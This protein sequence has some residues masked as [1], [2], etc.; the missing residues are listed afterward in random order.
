MLNVEEFVRDN[1]FGNGLGLCAVREP[2]HGRPALSEGLTIV[3][4]DSHLPLAEDIWFD[5][6]PEHLKDKAPRIWYDEKEKV[7]QIGFNGETLYPESAYPLIRS[8]EDRAGTFDLDARMADLDAEDVAKEIVF[9]QTLPMFF[10]HKDYEVRE[11]IFRGYNQYLAQLQARYPTRFFPVPVVNFW[12]PAEAPN[13][14][15]EIK[16]LG[17]KTLMLPMKP[18][19]KANGEPVVYASEEMDPMWAAIEKSGLPVCFHIGETLSHPGPNGFVCEALFQLGGAVFRRNFAELVFGGILDRHPDLQVVFAEGGISWVVS[20]LQDAE[21]AYDSYVGLLDYRPELRPSEYWH[22]NFYATFM[23]D[24]SGLREIDIIGADRAMWSS[25]YP[26]SEGTFGYSY[27]SMNKVI[28]AVPR[29]DAI[30][31]LGG[32]AMRVFGI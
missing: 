32:N 24:A 25:D 5:R 3:S 22:R 9:P 28:E 6:F 20:T 10:Q 21:M 18:G 11:W 8:M 14:V 27:T 26:H 31:I 19:M 7:N 2:D 23:N 16:A 12:D 17:L 4:S 15:R 30:K 13:S 29:E 1:S